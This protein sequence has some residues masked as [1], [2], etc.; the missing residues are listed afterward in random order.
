MK[1]GVVG[2][3]VIAEAHMRAWHRIKSGRVTAVCDSVEDRARRVA[4]KWN[5][6]SFYTDF[7]SMMR[8]EDLQFLSICTPPVAHAEQVRLAIELGVN[9]IV[10]K[11]L[12]MTAKDAEQIAE[13]CLRGKG[14]LAV[15]SNL[16]FEPVVARANR[17]L[18]SFHDEMIS[19]NVTFLKPATDPKS[20]D[21]SNW[22]HRLPGGLFGEMLFHPIYLLWFFLGEL[23]VRGI[24]LDKLGTQQWMPYDELT[25]FLS[26]AGKRAAMHLFYNSPRYGT[27]LDLHG[28]K[29]GLS[30]DMQNHDVCVLRNPHNGPVGKVVDCARQSF[31]VFGNA[32]DALLDGITYHLGI[33]HSG[34]DLNIA[35]FVES[36]A[37]GRPQLITVK[38]ACM[39]TR[40]QEEITTLIDANDAVPPSTSSAMH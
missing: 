32:R 26:S 33:Q 22:G 7:E 35:S 15:I 16:L 18:A 25:V 17:I 2:C 5:V 24:H 20:A 11:P 34:H 10:E 39:L 30:V 23:A 36:V 37:S 38:D 3:G 21:P 40:I 1:V 9:T 19:G 29:Y 14:K 12:A 13:V 8:R 27:F 6:P 28:R 31:T 4:E